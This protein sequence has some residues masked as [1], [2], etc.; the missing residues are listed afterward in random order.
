MTIQTTTKNLRK[1]GYS[2]SLFN[3]SKE[4][5]SHITQQESNKTIGIGGSVTIDQ[6]GLY[7]L[8]SVDNTVFWHWKDKDKDVTKNA[9]NAQVYITSANGVAETGEIVN[10][11]GNGNRL[12]A[13]LYG[14][15]KLYIIIGRNKIT[16]TLEQAIF[17]ARNIAAPLN[18]KRLNHNTPCFQSKELRCFDCNSS[19]RLCKAMTILFAP[20]NSITYCEVIIINEELGF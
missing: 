14:H 20:T 19:E 6:I 12:S 9:A 18:A 1:R 10:I 3:T 5:V 16:D 4:A 13:M 11:D 7:N 2:V 8:L 17:R 15:E